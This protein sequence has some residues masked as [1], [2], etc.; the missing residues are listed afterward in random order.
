MTVQDMYDRG[1]N[2]WLGREK[3]KGEWYICYHGTKTKESI[4]KIIKNNFKPGSRQA[5]EYEVNENPL[6][7]SYKTSVGSGIY[8]VY[9][10]LKISM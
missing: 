4:E 5:F 3:K 7:N 6:N 1:D 9:I 8:F 10:L 2:T